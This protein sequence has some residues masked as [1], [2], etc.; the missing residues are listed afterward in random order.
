[1]PLQNLEREALSRRDV[2]KIGAATTAGYAVAASPILAQAVR[3]DT[4]GLAVG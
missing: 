1:M 2:L 3:T 4:E